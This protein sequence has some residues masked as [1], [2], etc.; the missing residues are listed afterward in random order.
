MS[1]HRH[2]PVEFARLKAAKA[3][4]Q[5]DHGQGGGLPKAHERIDALAEVLGIVPPAK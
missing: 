1:K 2:D 5:Q 4:A 3:Q